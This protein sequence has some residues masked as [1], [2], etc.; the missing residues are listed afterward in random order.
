M[1][2][3]SFAFLSDDFDRTDIEEI[4]LSEGAMH[5]RMFKKFYNKKTINEDENDCDDLDNEDDIDIKIEDED[6]EIE[7]EDLP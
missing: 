7:E 5:E 4:D 3:E 2:R 6:L 1:K